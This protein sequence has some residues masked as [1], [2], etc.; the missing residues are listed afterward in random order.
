M[1]GFPKWIQAVAII[2]TAGTKKHTIFLLR[3]LFNWIFVFKYSTFHFPHTSKWTNPSPYF[4]HQVKYGRVFL[5]GVL[6]NG[7]SFSKKNQEKG[8][9][10]EIELSSYVLFSCWRIFL[11][12]WSVAKWLGWWM[13]NGGKGCISMW[14]VPFVLSKK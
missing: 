11:W 14:V 12:W 2:L 5:I 10:V 4:P 1:H 9:V 6:E 3:Y 13:E 8:K 7:F